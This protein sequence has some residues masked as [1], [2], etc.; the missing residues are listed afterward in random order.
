MGVHKNLDSFVLVHNDDILGPALTTTREYGA[1]FSSTFDNYTSGQRLFLKK[2]TKSGKSVL[3][4]H[5]GTRIGDFFDARHL[6][7]G[8]LKCWYIKADSD[9]IPQL[10]SY[11]LADMRDC[12]SKD[13]ERVLRVYTLQQI[14]FYIQ[15]TIDKN[16]KLGDIAL[17]PKRIQVHDMADVIMP[18]CK[19]N[20]RRLF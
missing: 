15:M 3:V 6:D 16:F 4:S 10:A 18:F 12:I 14:E 17:R 1:W 20:K 2:R 7:R 11:Q 9:M 19:S 8:D 13:K 5:P